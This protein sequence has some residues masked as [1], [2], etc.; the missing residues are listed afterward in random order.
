MAALP[1]TDSPTRE[2]RLLDQVRRAYAGSQ[3]RVRVDGSLPPL[4]GVEQ[5]AGKNGTIE[6]QLAAGNT[7]QQV[8]QQLVQRQAAVEHFEI[9]VPTLVIRCE[10][11]I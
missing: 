4:A 2:T 5:T 8:L 7:P 10:E 3:V 1:P 9:A 11:P 6:L